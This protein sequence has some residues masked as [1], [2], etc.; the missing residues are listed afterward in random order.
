[1]Y[2][3]DTPYVSKGFEKKAVSTLTSIDFAGRQAVIHNTGPSVLYFCA[4]ELT[5]TTDA[6]ELAVG[7]KT[8]TRTGSLSLLSAGTSNLKI[9][10][11]EQVG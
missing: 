4:G 7:E 5:A 6:P 2:V 1:M 9:E 11:V 8:F 3:T 10:Y